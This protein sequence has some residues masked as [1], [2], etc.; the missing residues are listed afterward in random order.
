M[1]NYIERKIK[2]IKFEYDIFIK[3][4]KLSLTDYISCMLEK[5]KRSQK[6][7]IIQVAKGRKVQFNLGRFVPSQMYHLVKME[8]WGQWELT[9]I[10]K[11]KLNNF[12]DEALKNIQS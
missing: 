7:Y 5:H 1:E 6:I 2:Y 9:D 12:Y 4:N 10:Y 8:N 11:E 3:Q